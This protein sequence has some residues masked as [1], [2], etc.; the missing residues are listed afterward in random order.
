M[1]QFSRWLILAFLVSWC[2]PIDIYEIQYTTN[3]G[4]SSECYPS[5]LVGTKVNT[6]GVVTSVHQDSL[7]MQT[8]AAAWSG[9]SIYTGTGHPL[10][11]AVSIGDQLNVTATVAEF[12]GMTVLQNISYYI[13]SS[14]GNSVG[15]ALVTSDQLG[16]ACNLAGEAYEGV[17]VTMEDVE[18]GSDGSCDAISIHSQGENYTRMSLGS[19][20]LLSSITG[21]WM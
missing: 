15:A 14:S 7:T 20:T 16:S 17:L 8:A 3:A 4:A 12:G 18:V 13:I 19:G 2:S 10:L 9:I 11:S 21:K 5:L 1:P 6:S